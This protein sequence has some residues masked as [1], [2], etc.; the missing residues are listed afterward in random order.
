MR[1]LAVLTALAFGSAALAADKFTKANAGTWQGVGIQIDG[2]EWSMSLSID[3]TASEVA[4]DG[5][6][7]GGTWTHIRVTDDRIVAVEKLTAGLDICLDGGLL[8]VER[9]DENSLL[10]S[11]FDKA[12]DVVA[13]AVLVEGEFRQDRYPALRQLTL[14]GLGKGF[15]KGPDAAMRFGDDRI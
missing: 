2:Q 13:S 15:V 8:Q 6:K 1:S 12:G 14:D 10:Y 3:P 4:Y 11:Y 9:F 7:C 5:G